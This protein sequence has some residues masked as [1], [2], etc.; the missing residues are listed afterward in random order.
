MAF[1][2]DQA[3]TGGLWGIQGSEIIFLAKRVKPEQVQ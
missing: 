3:Q 1:W 2:H